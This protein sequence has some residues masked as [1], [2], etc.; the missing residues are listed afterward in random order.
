MSVGTDKCSSSV[1]TYR[2]TLVGIAHKLTT[3]R[4]P[5]FVPVRCE[6]YGMLDARMFFRQHLSDFMADCHH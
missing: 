6:K 2:H 4:N 5:P 3:I 1:C